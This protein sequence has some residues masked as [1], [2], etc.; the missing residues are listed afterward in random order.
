[1]GSLGKANFMKRLASKQHLIRA[2][3]GLAIGMVLAIVS[4]VGA[5]FDYTPGQ[6]TN[7]AWM[8]LLALPVVAWG[9]SHLARLRGYPSA[10]AYGLVVAGMFVSGFV[11]MAPSPL[12]V[13]FMFIFVE[14]LPV[15][16]L[17]ALPDKS[18]RHRR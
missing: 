9:C 14:L 3:V 15:G 10:A 16:V 12:V 11:V 18:F 13:G 1:M 8:V 5:Y 6:G 7:W 2:I 17:L 4:A